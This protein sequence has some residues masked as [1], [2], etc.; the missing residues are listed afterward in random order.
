MSSITAALALSQFK[1]INK[2]IQ[3][4][5]E[6]ASY[7]NKKLSKIKNIKIP[8]EVKDHFHVYQM[9]TIQLENRK[10][11]EKLQQTLQNQEL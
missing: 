1:K 2:I 10:L 9:Y 8:A 5:R 4:R 7:Y 3:M 6:K 11:R